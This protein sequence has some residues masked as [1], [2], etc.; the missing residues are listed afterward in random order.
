VEAAPV[1]ELFARPRHPYTLG[2]LESI[3]RLDQKGQQLNAIKG[4]PPSLLEIPPGC[5]FHPR[6]PMARENCR[7]DEPPLYDVG[8][9]RSS[10][11]HYWREMP[12]AP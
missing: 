6:C 9:R 4:L 11:C 7:V 2:L 8:A 3:P 10:A 1:D 12:D 5:A